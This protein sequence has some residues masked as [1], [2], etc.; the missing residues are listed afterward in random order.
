MFVP[1]N[2]MQVEKYLLL[3]DLVPFWQLSGLA[4]SYVAKTFAKYS[5]QKSR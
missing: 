5:S 4:W 3:L 2:L 1:T